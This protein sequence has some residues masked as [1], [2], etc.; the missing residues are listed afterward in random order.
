[1]VEGGGSDCLPVR[2]GG[3]EV[4][5]ADDRL[6]A[7]EEGGVEPL[8]MQIIDSFFFLGGLITYRDI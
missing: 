6:Y 7:L 1:M 4:V 5:A 2:G 3:R 8:L